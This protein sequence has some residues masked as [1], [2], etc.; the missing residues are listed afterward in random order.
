MPI[1]NPKIESII[2]LKRGG[3]RLWW[4]HH[5]NLLLNFW[6]RGFGHDNDRWHEGGK[7]VK[8]HAEKL[9]T[10][11]VN[12][13]LCKSKNRSNSCCLNFRKN[14]A[15]GMIVL[16]TRWRVSSQYYNRKRQFKLLPKITIRS[17]QMP[18]TNG[19]EESRFLAGFL[20]KAVD[21]S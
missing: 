13:P 1:I 16:E 4:R 14:F 10:S 7:G 15:H 18:A 20:I 11:Y 6:G 17:A 21:F 5:G 8:M 9:M 12:D 3:A 19:G 2:D